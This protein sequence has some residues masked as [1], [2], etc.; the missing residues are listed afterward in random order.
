MIIFTVFA[1]AALSAAAIFPI[2]DK[3]MAMTVTTSLTCFLPYLVNAV[4][5]VQYV[6][7]LL[8]V[9]DRY[10]KLNNYLDDLANDIIRETGNNDIKL[11]CSN[12]LSI[13]FI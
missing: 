3:S 1:L 10:T 9:K 4:M 8:F 13:F 11:C 5:E 2:I 6:C 7:Y 12:N